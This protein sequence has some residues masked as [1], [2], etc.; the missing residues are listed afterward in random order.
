MKLMKKQK[1]AALLLVC[2]ILFQVTYH[3][4][5]RPNVVYATGA[6]G[7]VAGGA[8]AGGLGLT[9]PEVAV[10]IAALFGVAAV[11][12]NADAI[13]TE[14]NNCINK[15]TDGL[16]N[17]A[18]I[19]ADWWKEAAAGVVDTTSSVWKGV[20][21]WFTGTREQNYNITVGSVQNV[22]AGEKV[23]WI[24]YGR[25]SAYGVASA[26]CYCVEYWYKQGENSR[27]Y[28]G[29]MWITYEK[30][31]WITMYYNGHSTNRSI[32]YNKNYDF[33]YY[34]D[35][36]GLTTASSENWKDTISKYLPNAYYLGQYDLDF[37]M[38]VD[39]LLSLIQPYLGTQQEKIMGGINKVL[40]ENIIDDAA[41]VIWP[42]TIVLNPN[43]AADEELASVLE[44]LRS[45]ELTWTDC[46]D[47]VASG[48]RVGVKTDA[49][50]YVLDNAGVTDV[51]YE[52]DATD[53]PPAVNTPELNNSLAD[54]KT[55]GLIS[56][57]P[58]CV[59]FDLINCIKLM[60]ATGQAPCWEFPFRVPVLGL[61][62]TIKIDLTK[63]DSVAA[64][65]RSLE[66]LLFVGLLINKTRALIRG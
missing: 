3:C 64:V 10:A 32:D 49:G 8:V 61:E 59:P 9:G 26:D 31:A 56:L 50:T 25:G 13:Y 2:C 44:K 29:R 35:S 53:A 62:D 20:C 45:G 63:W 19:V 65:C 21:N 58:F 5:V 54:Y 66:T 51:P 27:Y 36:D 11:V 48:E 12:D 55:D 6:G 39:N 38:T 4:V 1:C 40:D 41:D 16:E 52:K 43:L 15:V 17:Q 23:N 24:N 28:F 22:K 46:W 14:M 18:T 7:A 57:F 60:A 47:R 42:D 34:N 33:Y 37:S 30:N